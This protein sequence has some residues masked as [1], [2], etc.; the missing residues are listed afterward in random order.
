METCAF[1][2]DLRMNPEFPEAYQRLRDRAH[3]LARDRIPPLVYR[4]VKR[5]CG[6][7]GDSSD[8]GGSASPGGGRCFRFKTDLHLFHAAE[9]E[10]TVDEVLCTARHLLQVGH[11]GTAFAAAELAFITGW[12]KH[13][14]KGVPVLRGAV[15]RRLTS[16]YGLLPTLST[17]GGRVL[18][19]LNANDAPRG[20][21]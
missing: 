19:T 8:S 9:A 17:C 2:I 6:D 15:W 18:V 21:G 14:E 20:F 3:T 13:S 16:Q 11:R 7:R 4:A 5:A 1:D 12:G 10:R